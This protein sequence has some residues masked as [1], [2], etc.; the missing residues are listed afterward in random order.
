MILPV[1]NYYKCVGCEACVD[2]C[3]NEIFESYIFDDKVMVEV[4]TDGFCPQCNDCQSYCE[5]DAIDF[6][7]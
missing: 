5:H 2:V 4:N 3:N 6:Q 7:E 1:I